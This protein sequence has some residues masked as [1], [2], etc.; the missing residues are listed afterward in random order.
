MFFLFFSLESF[1][2]VSEEELMEED[3]DDSV[4][5][6]GEESPSSEVRKDGTKEAAESEGRLTEALS[7]P[8]T[9]LHSEEEEEEESPNGENEMK[10]GTNTESGPTPAV[11]EWQHI[12]MVCI[13]LLKL[14]RYKHVIL[15]LFAISLLLDVNCFLID[16][17][18]SLR[19]RQ[20]I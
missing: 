15:N 20:I 8:A 10:E 7:H 16:L 2:E 17:F 14:R 19:R 1:I 5:T 11:S 9:A 13:S 12:D 4:V 18:D 3:A 6:I